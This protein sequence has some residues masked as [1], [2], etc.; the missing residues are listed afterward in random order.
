MATTTYASGDAEVA[1][2]W[3]KRLARES[4]KATEIYKFCED[5]TDALG[6]INTSLQKT[7][8]DRVTQ[9]LR[10]QP[11]GRGGSESTPMEG[12]EEALA[13][14]TENVT[15]NEINHA[16]RGKKGGVVQQRIPWEIGFELNDALRDWFAARIDDIAFAHLAGYVPYNSVDGL[17][18][19]VYNGHNT[20]TAPTSGR[21]LWCSTDHTTDATLDSDDIFALSHIDRARE[22]AETGGSGNLVPIR[23]IKNDML[24]GMGAEYVCFIHPSQV[25]QLRASSTQWDNIQK[26]IL[27]GGQDPKKNPLINGKTV[28][29]YNNTLLVSSSRV[30]PGVN[31]GG[32]A[33]QA[34]TRRAVF[35]G[36]Q[37]LTLAFGKGYGPEK[38]DVV[39]ELFD[40]KRNVG[41]GGKMVGG[42]KKCVFGDTPSDFATIVLSSYSPAAA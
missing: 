35:C 13:T 37:A 31:A 6:C 28:G 36:A 21:H 5:S 2:Y 41:F 42:I 30:K 22:I 29:V 32:T 19:G 11:T 39:E 15:I 23:P 9:T 40:Y 26:A 12:N 34:N 17:S 20:I 14:G 4:L 16:L 33:A 1:K 25:T 3:E 7:A 8:G 38:F 27:Q 24:N 10:Y 18:D